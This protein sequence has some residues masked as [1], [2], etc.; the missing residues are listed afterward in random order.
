MTI[1]KARL[2][3]RGLGASLGAGFTFLLGLALYFTTAGQWAVFLSYDVP[4]A[5]RHPATPTNA[6]I[7]YLDDYSHEVM[8]EPKNRAWN[9]TRHADLVK[10]LTDAGVAAVVFDVIFTDESPAAAPGESSADG[11]LAEAI[12]ANGKVVLL[13]GLPSALYTVLVNVPSGRVVLVKR[14]DAS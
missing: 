12:K 10:R 13:V 4:F 3:Q 2:R 5:F 8:K 9:R 1:W 6:L 11:K 7:V 14:L